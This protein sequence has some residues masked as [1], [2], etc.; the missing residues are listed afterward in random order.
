MDGFPILL[1]FQI[2]K[3]SSK[4]VLYLNETEYQVIIVSARSNREGLLRSAPIIAR[5]ELQESLLWPRLLP[6]LR[7][8]FSSSKSNCVDEAG[9]DLSQELQYFTDGFFL[10]PQF[11]ENGI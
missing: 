9:A 6:L 1:H 7:D 2:E 3:S 5:L 4:T 10:D 11:I 8:S